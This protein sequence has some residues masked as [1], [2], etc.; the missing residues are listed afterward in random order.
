VCYLNLFRQNSKLKNGG[1]V[2]PEKNAGL[3]PC[4]HPGSATYGLI[5]HYYNYVERLGI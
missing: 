4:G 5:P 1:P 3:G 2:P